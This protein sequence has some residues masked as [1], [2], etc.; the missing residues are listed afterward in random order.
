MTRETKEHLEK[1]KNGLIES[2]K[3]RAAVK[4]AVTKSQEKRASEEIERQKN[5]V[6]IF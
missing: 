3:K 5:F 4:H 1:S 6:G 2:S